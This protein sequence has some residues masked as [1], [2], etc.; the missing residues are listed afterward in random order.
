MHWIHS[1]GFKDTLLGVPAELILTIVNVT[2]FSRL[3]PFVSLERTANPSM[4]ELSKI[5]DGNVATISCA[6]TRFPARV[7]YTRLDCNSNML[8]LIIDFAS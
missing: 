4:A 1:P 7:R 6:K 8:L 2:G 3:A 5:G